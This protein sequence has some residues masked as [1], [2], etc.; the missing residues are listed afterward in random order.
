MAKVLFLRHGV[1]QTNVKSGT[2]PLPDTVLQL[3]PA[4]NLNLTGYKLSY[5]L[6]TFIKE[7]FGISDII[8]TDVSSPRNVDT[9]ISLAQGSGNNFI[10]VDKKGTE[11]YFD[12]Y[13]PVNK[14]TIKASKRALKE[15]KQIILDIKQ[16][17]ENI[18]NIK[19]ENKSRSKTAKS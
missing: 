5:N 11:K 12:P 1:R 9:A 13:I 18:D 8:Y 10:S 6:G 2:E 17:I 14:K 15:N 7:T 4:S 16:A 3:A 19:L